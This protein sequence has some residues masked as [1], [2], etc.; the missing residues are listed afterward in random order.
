MPQSIAPQVEPIQL[1]TGFLAIALGIVLILEMRANPLK[2]L[3]SVPLLGLAIHLILY[4]TVLSLDR[5]NF[6]TFQV[7]YTNWSSWLRLHEVGTLLLVETA[8]WRLHRSLR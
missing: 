2:K 4:Y 5:S 6:I 8:R 3:W 1:F 7:T